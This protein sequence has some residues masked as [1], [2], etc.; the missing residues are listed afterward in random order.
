MENMWSIFVN[1][2]T[3]GIIVIVAVP[4]YVTSFFDDKDFFSFFG[5]L[6]GKDDS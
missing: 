2:E 5:E 4:S 1:Q 3:V 6:L